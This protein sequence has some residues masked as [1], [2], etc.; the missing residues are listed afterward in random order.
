MTIVNMDSIRESLHHL[1]T[2]ITAIGRQ[3]PP[4]QKAACLIA[5]MPVEIVL[6]LAGD[7]PLENQLV[8]AQ[9]CRAFYALLR[10]TR[11][12]RRTRKQHIHYLACIAR[13]MPSHWVCGTC[14]KL[15]R[16]HP[17]DVPWTTLH[18]R[19]RLGWLWDNCVRSLNCSKIQYNH[20]HIQLA[21]KRLEVLLSPVYGRCPTSSSTLANKG[22][23]WPKVVGGRFLIFTKIH[24]YPDAAYSYAPV[25]PDNL[26]VKSLCQHQHFYP[27]CFVPT[28]EQLRS[29]TKYK[30]WATV[31]EAFEAGGKEVSGS[32]R[33]C[34]LDMSFQATPEHATLRVWRDFGPE[35]SPLDLDWEVFTNRN[36]LVTE[37]LTVPYD[38][39]GSVRRLY[40]TVER[41]HD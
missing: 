37:T 20:H 9:T 36:L 39:P 41:G 28:E 38:E 33:Q 23:V 14:A 7:L 8:L 1:E 40:E 22:I 30:I 32:C 6:L 31:L 4:A 18:N 12:A 3:P 34:R 16:D 5:Q 11:D 21:L 19:C 24:Y 13:D 25:T 35:G 26:D 27:S 29:Q 15:H 17:D 2:I 10:R